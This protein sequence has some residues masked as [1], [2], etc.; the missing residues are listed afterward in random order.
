MAKDHKDE[1]LW[2]NSDSMTSMEG[3]KKNTSA[4]KLIQQPYKHNKGVP[5]RPV[6]EEDN[7]SWDAQGFHWTGI[8]SSLHALTSTGY[9]V[10]SAVRAFTNNGSLAFKEM[11]L[12]LRTGLM[13]S[14]MAHEKLEA[15]MA[16]YPDDYTHAS[17]VGFHDPI[18]SKSEAN[19]NIIRSAM[20][21]TRNC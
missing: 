14:Q 10:G 8:P 17:S 16:L 9:D 2:Y 5:I 20:G 19:P 3:G 15:H 6:S 18:F 21:P 12:L 13:R 4:A 7:A 1:Q 11:P